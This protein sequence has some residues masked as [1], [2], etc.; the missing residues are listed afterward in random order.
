[1][2]AWFARNSV[3]ANLLMALIILGGFLSIKTELEM[4]V[5]PSIAPNQINISVALRAATPE[6]VELG[7]ATRIEEALSDLEG[8][9]TMTSISR[10]GGTRVSLELLSDYDPRDMLDDVKS[11]VDAINGLPG[12]IEKP[13]ISL[14]MR[15]FSVITVAIGGTQSQTELTE[16]AERV[17]D[18]LLGIEGI[19]Q[20]DLDAVA[21]Y[22]IAIETSQDKLNLWGITLDEIANAIR[23]NSLDSSAGNLRTAGG[24]I[25]LRSKGQAYRK[26]EFEDIVIKTDRNGSIIRVAD[27]AKVH[28]GF[29]DEGL[30]SRFNG[31]NSVY[32]DVGRVGKQSALDVADKVKSYINDHQHQVPEGMV[33]SYWDDDSKILRDR[34]GILRDNAIQGTILVLV[35][36]TLFLRPS[37][38]LWVFLGIPVSFLGALIVMS[39]LGQSLNIMS[40]FGF[41]V[42]LGIVVD[43]AIVTG[44]NVYRH[45]K[46]SSSGLD[47]AIKGTEEVAVPVTFGVLTTI[48]AFLPLSFIEGRIGDLF[49]PIS[50]VVIAALIFSLIE[51]KFVLP[52]HLK[53]VKIRHDQKSTGF[54]KWQ[55][56]FANGFEDKIKEYY[57]PFLNTCIEHRYTTLISFIGVLTLI[58][59]L[60]SSGWMKFTFWQTVE[61]DSG[62]ISITMPVGT[63]FEVT[64]K[65]VAY[66]TNEVRKLQ[67]KY[68]NPE[69]GESSIIAI[70]SIAG[71][72]GGRG[73]AANRGRISFEVTP[74]ELR[75]DDISTSSLINELRKNIGDIAGAESL[76]FR[77]SLW[78][79]GSPLDVQFSANS[80]KQLDEVSNQLK[81]YLRT[82][83]DVYEIND[84]MS[85]G[86]QEIELEL[87]PQGEVLGFSRSELLRQIGSA[88][89]GAEAQRIQRGRSDIR[90]IVRL[91]REERSQFDSL[92]NML[93]K[94]PAGNKVPLSEV[95]TLIPGKG[96]SQI[97]RIDGM[98]VINVRAEVNKAQAN[99]TVIKSNLVNFI[100]NLLQQYP[101]VKYSLE[102]EEKFQ[103]ESF[104]SMESGLIMVVIAIFVLLAL[105][106]KSYSQPLIIMSVIPFGLIGAVV[107]HA[108]IGLDLTI[109][110]L[111]GMMALVGI[112]VNDSLVL[113]DYINRQHSS[114]LTIKEAVLSAGTARFRAVLLTS[115]TTFFGVLPLILE[116]SISAQFLIPMA[117]SMGFGVL[118]ATAITLILVPTN[119]M[120]VDDIKAALGRGR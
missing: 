32:I 60:L 109:Y 82:V 70:R 34:L 45:L 26:G 13:I 64:D 117:I 43:D 49:I 92:R 71:N 18:D 51:S 46:T 12:D 7:V 52:A 28:D 41:I 77:S 80:F 76:E 87:T 68:R 94:T 108:I 14:A 22:E 48:V 50:F 95:A 89:K 120:I 96:P 8:I 88:F 6:D 5:F 33:L 11:R 27:V 44:E 75:H 63:P 47:A 42:V 1:M 107:G 55:N 59:A 98:R 24:D 79:M 86:K 21:N 9:D 90:V 111:M 67:D 39:H 54:T 115:L 56:N 38:A 58:F 17:R 99:M 30:T 81:D 23:R 84:S 15:K 113:V 4:E 83:P 57:Q 40:A 78:R 16:F 93:V 35:L 103:R 25:L 74:R 97:T 91:T 65:H 73:A 69:T 36:L 2:I 72:G 102:G 53:H 104:G 116:N 37:V 66:I 20:V 106:L 85:D 119:V 61:S 31:L 118:F 100:D 29:E 101:N 19:T 62:N 10:E 3:A 105:P 112:L 114:G 110:S